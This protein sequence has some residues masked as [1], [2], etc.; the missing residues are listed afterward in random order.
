MSNDDPIAAAELSAFTG[1][2][3]RCR[4]FILTSVLLAS[5]MLLHVFLERS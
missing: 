5:L 4:W 2:A 3:T 1:V